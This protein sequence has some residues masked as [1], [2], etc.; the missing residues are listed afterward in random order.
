MAT[1]KEAAFAVKVFEEYKENGKRQ[2]AAVAYDEAYEAVKAYAEDEH[3]WYLSRYEETMMNTN[4][5][6][7]VRGFWD[8]YQDATWQEVQERLTLAKIRKTWRDILLAT[9]KCKPMS[10]VVYED[11][12]DFLAPSIFD[13]LGA[14][15]E[16][17]GPEQ[18]AERLVKQAEILGED[19]LLVIAEAMRK[20]DNWNR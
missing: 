16:A 14:G 9:G 5:L 19:K 18:A 10:L 12:L 17:E 4:A 11:L 15:Q 20:L 3:A 1:L 13:W 2:A 7:I 8:E 6:E